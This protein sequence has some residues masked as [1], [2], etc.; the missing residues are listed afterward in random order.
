MKKIAIINAKIKSISPLHIGDDE[1]EVLIYYD[2]NMAYLPATSIAGSFRAYLKTIGED[3]ESLFG[4]HERN[5]NIMSSIY[6]S[7][8]FSSISNFEKRDGLKIDGS[9]GCNAHGLKIDKLYLGEGLEFDLNFEIHA[10]EEEIISYKNMIYKCLNA[11]DKNHIRFG[12]KKSSGLGNF[13][14]L[15]ASEIEFNFNKII[16]YEKY[17]KRDYDNARDIKDEILSAKLDSIFVKF[18]MEGEFTGPLLIK[19]PERFELGAPDDSSLKS[20]G[21]YIVPGSSFKGILRSRVRKIADY[22]GN[23][24]TAEEMFGTIIGNKNKN[25][26]SRVAVNESKIAD[27]IEN[28]YH[29]IKVDRYTGGVRKG[30]LMH[31]MPISG[32]TEFNVIYKKCGDKKIDD[33]ATGIL[34]LALRDLGMEDLPIGS[35]SSIGRGRFKANIMSISNGDDTINI[36]FTNRKID[37]EEKLREYIAAV[38]SCKGEVYFNGEEA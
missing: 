1:G 25:R 19:A 21:E 22:F 7:D 36:D 38:E 12:G 6:I 24:N 27:S 37:G 28:K 29:R 10:K 8:S 13:M 15:S 23:Q 5:K 17:L 30:S 33:Y 9:M 32:K 14:L 2:S 35:G 31:D 34:A 16:H 18:T 26:L 20:N 4:T 11:L 3:Y